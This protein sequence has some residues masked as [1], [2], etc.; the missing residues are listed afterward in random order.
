M[1]CVHVCACMCVYVCMH[2]CVCVCMCVH[3]CVYV[4]VHVC[5]CMCVCMCVH[6]C[7]CYC[8]LHITW[9]LSG[10]SNVL[11]TCSY[12]GNTVGLT[13][14]R[15]GMHLDTPAPKYMPDTNILRI[16]NADVN[17]SGTYDCVVGSTECPA[18]YLTVV[19][20]MYMIGDLIMQKV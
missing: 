7:V 18:G 20:G 10:G 13:W 5:V 9:T 16:M 8:M 19:A 6:A 2:V 14:K 17:D 15:N 4:C 11:I 12:N 3:A 1:L